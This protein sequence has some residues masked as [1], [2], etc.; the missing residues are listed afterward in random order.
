MR[1]QL[2]LVTRRELVE[3]LRKRYQEFPQAKRT[4]ILDEFVEVTGYHRKHAIRLL[5]RQALLH[6]QKAPRSKSRIYNEA[7]RESLIVLWEAADR[8]C[9]KR[10]KPL[11]PLLV[12]TMERHGHLQVEGFSRRDAD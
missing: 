9:G 7:V 1:E 12:E 8:I 6:Q 3:A 10:L 2:S 5:G 11:I 4:A